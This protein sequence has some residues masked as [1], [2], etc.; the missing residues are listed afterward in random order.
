MAGKGIVPLPDLPLP[1]S[2]TRLADQYH[3]RTTSDQ[4]SFLLH[5]FF[6]EKKDRVTARAP[7]QVNSRQYS[8]SSTPT[9]ESYRFKNG[10]EK[11]TQQSSNQFDLNL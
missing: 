7:Y 6:G 3:Q 11:K 1:S 8:G 2:P 9:G 5:R 4:K 10:D